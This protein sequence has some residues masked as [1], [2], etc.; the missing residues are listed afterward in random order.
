MSNKGVVTTNPLMNIVCT[1]TTVL[2]HIEE[3]ANYVHQ[4][5]MPAAAVSAILSITPTTM[6]S[7]TDAKCAENASLLKLE[8]LVGAGMC[9]DQ[10][11]TVEE[12]PLILLQITIVVSILEALRVLVV[13]SL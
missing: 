5:T 2:V 11:P 12:T 6:A 3:R 4:V 9:T 10:F 7:F 1:A 13:M 8:L